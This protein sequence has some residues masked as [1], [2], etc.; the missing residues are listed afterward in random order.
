MILEDFVG[1]T[2][3]FGL[4]PIAKLS[5]VLFISFERPLWLSM[6]KDLSLTGLEVYQAVDEC[7]LIDHTDPCCL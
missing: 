7:L 2:I 3:G 5:M 6:P 1:Q 4:S